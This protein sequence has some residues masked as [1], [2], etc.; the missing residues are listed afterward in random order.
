MVQ[1]HVE[2]R[3]DLLKMIVL[4]SDQPFLELAG[5]VIIDQG[6]RPHDF[7]FRLDDDLLNQGVANQITKRLGPVGVPSLL[8]QLIELL[9]KIIGDG[10]TD[11]G[12]IVHLRALL[13]F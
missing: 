4:L 7:L 13:L 3:N 5:M 1:V 9:Q 12:E 6:Q 2:R 8:D 10:H 11:A